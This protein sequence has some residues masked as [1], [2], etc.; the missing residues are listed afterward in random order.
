LQYAL[1]LSLV[2]V[3]LYVTKYSVAQCRHA[4]FFGSKLGMG[5][6]IAGLQDNASRH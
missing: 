5:H 2:F 6:I 1:P 3:A 4:T